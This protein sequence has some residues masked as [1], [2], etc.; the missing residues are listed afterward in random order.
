M[1]ESDLC[2]TCRAVISGERRIQD[3][4][5]WFRQPGASTRDIFNSF[6]HL[7]HES[8]NQ[9]AASKESGCIPCSLL[10]GKLHPPHKLHQKGEAAPSGEVTDGFHVYLRNE[11]EHNRS[12]SGSLTFYAVCPW[13]SDVKQTGQFIS[14]LHTIAILIVVLVF[15]SQQK[16]QP[17]Q[18]YG[19]AN[20]LDPGPRS[21][22]PSEYLQSRPWANVGATMGSDQSLKVIKDWLLNCDT[23]HSF[24]GKNSKGLF[25][26]TRCIDVGE[27]E[28]GTVSLRDRDE[29]KKLHS[30][31]TNAA[32]SPTHLEHNTRSYDH[33]PAYL[34]LSHRWGDPKR[35]LQL[36]K[37]DEK[38]FRKGIQIQELSQTFQ[39]AM[40]IVKRLG[41]QYIWID[42]L[43][44]FQDSAADWQKEADIMIDVYSNTFC[45]ISAISSSYDTN[46]GLFSERLESAQ[47]LFPFTAETEVWC[48]ENGTIHGTWGFG[49]A[50]L[51]DDEIE[52][53]PLSIRGWVV[54]ERFLSPRII[55][56]AQSQLFWECLEHTSCEMDPE[57]QLDLLGSWSPYG[58]KKAASA[59][60][61]SSLTVAQTL[62][63]IEK[64]GLKQS[65]PDWEEKLRTWSD[66]KAHRRPWRTMV[67]IYSTCDL[68][69]ESDRLIAMSGIAK[70][71]QEVDG[72][73]YLAGLWRRA[74]HTDLSWH[75]DTDKGTPF[76]RNEAYAP[77]WS[78]AS[79]RSGG[80]SIYIANP[81][82]NGEPSSFIKFLDAR[83]Q[84][85]NP[86][87][88]PMGLLR[89]AELD[90]ECLLC[91]F[92]WLGTSKELK[93]YRTK[94]MES[95]LWIGN[96]QNLHL[97][98]AN[99]IERFGTT[100]EIDGFVVPL[101]S[102]YASHGGGFVKLL[103]L[104]NTGG[105]KYTRIGTFTWSGIGGIGLDHLSGSERITL[106]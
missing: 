4:T 47:L 76:R 102:E 66:L 80:V 97:D 98:T 9:L 45:N 55:H 72:D 105:N 34:T 10:W 106:I 58:Q 48:G 75:T 15:I 26:P 96:Q 84:P 5:G 78:W 63:K 22:L 31:A 91:Y 7:H 38:R 69:K 89:S 57:G 24:C 85:A 13:A 92:R 6:N 59:Y 104:E 50:D 95:T 21:R 61:A 19:S 101:F 54:Q 82:G 86:G 44:I 83:L 68:T 27:I 36:R 100:D 42:S 62:E 41:Y 37:G 39:D 71:F 11:L 79:I 30:G 87:G 103:L 40:W 16:D 46:R 94:E 99:L 49:N 1:V 3:Q 23:N 51:W 52:R 35:I 93:I 25:F 2:K 90:I 70:R 53:A 32:P 17:S 73:T 77:S 29:V 74:L 60:K 43:C 65:D 56:F 64:W 14:C 88:D 28:K 20:Y 8:Y 81:R 33:Y 18:S 12:S 67:G